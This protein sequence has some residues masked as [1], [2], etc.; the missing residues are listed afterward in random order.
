VTTVHAKT[1]LLAATHLA[2]TVISVTVAL[3]VMHHVDLVATHLAVTVISVTVALVAIHL[4]DL[5]QTHAEDAQE[6]LVVSARAAH[7]QR[8]ATNSDLSG[9]VSSTRPLTF[10]PH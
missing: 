2:A 3:A 5:V 10:C 6:D 1:V 4:A 7:A 9:L 8:A